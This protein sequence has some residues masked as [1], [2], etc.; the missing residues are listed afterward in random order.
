M[1]R[2]TLLVTSVGSRAAEGI[3][4]ALGPLRRHVRIVA[5]NSIAEAPGL[6]EADVAYLVPPTAQADAFFERMK[7]I[8]RSER[9]HL[10][11]NGR[12]EEIALLARLAGDAACKGTDF[13][14]PP[15]ELAHCFND[16]YLTATFAREHGLPFA[17][18]AFTGDELAGLIA[19][20]GFP[21]IAKPRKGGHASR[22]VFIVLSESQAWRLHA[23]GNTLFQ[24]FIGKHLVHDDFEAWNGDQGIPWTWNPRNTYHMI[25]FVL[26]RG[27]ELLAQCMT[28]AERMGS[29][30]QSL[31][32]VEH[33]A[34]QD[35]ARRHV[36]ALRAAGHRGPVN[37]Q[38][39]IDPEG[40]FQ[41]F[42]WNAR[43]VGSIPGYA[44][45]GVNLV[46]AALRHYLPELAEVPH[47][48]T[49]PRMVFRPLAFRG[50]PLSAVDALRRNGCL[51]G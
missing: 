6:Y 3:L 19:S 11:L 10:V 26:G 42:E 41:A 48:E 2:P 4:A 23:R 20:H 14:L 13:L 25:D 36:D 37:I 29:V 5:T 38:G 22:D 1:T 18:T 45:L 28:E 43:F 33:P 15:A 9:P 12:D 46:D 27:G 17:P 21:L 31:R 32:L 39:C 50:V 34:L 30:V 16:K 35:A 49:T 24:A 51:E 40:R 44:L 8:I 7:T 47:S